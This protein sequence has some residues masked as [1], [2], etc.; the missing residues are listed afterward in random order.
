LAWFEK[1]ISRTVLRNEP[2]VTS[3]MTAATMA[4]RGAEK[5]GVS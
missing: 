4:N 5:A 1:S 2:I 3:T